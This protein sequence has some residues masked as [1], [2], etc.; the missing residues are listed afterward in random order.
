MCQK[1]GID[2]KDRLQNNAKKMKFLVAGPMPGN[3]VFPHGYQDFTVIHDYLQTNTP[4][5]QVRLRKRG[6]NVCKCCLFY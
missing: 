1:L 3:E 4:K 6:Q 2:A 5:M